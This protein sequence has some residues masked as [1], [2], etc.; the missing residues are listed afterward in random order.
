M[1]YKMFEYLTKRS[2]NKILKTVTIS[3]NI[4]DIT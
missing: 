1:K 2:K 3:L 4:Y